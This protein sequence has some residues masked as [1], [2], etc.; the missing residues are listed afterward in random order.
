MNSL[1]LALSFLTILP[2]APSTGSGNFAASRAYFP[3]V[4]LLIGGILAIEDAALRTVV[5]PLFMAALLV[6]TLVVLTRALHLEGLVDI[7]DDLFGGYTP[8]CRL[9]IMKDPHMGVFCGIGVVRVILLKWMAIAALPDLH[10]TA[11]LIVFPCLSRWAMLLA[12]TSFRYVRPLG[13]GAAFQGEGVLAVLLVG[14]VTALAASFLLL[15]E[16]GVLT[17]VVVTAVAL[18]LGRFIASMLGG[19]LTG[20]AYRAINEASEVMGL[21]WAGATS[22]LALG[23]L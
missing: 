11:I 21:L 1:R 9:E 3:L 16:A 8:E 10:R 18:I 13:T 17:F 12:L 22:G 23:A 7:C 14:C 5:P 2:A 20:D 4:G 15:G 19:G 6:V